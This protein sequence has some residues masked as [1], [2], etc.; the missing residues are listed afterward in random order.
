MWIPSS[1]KKNVP[2]EFY[3]KEWWLRYSSKVLHVVHILIMHDE[4]ILPTSTKSSSF[5]LKKHEIKFLMTWPKGTGSGG[6]KALPFI[7][8]IVWSI[9]IRLK[10]QSTV[11]GLCPCYVISFSGHILTYP[12]KNPMF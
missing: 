12:D 6:I 2:K 11:V 1:V 3:L 7:Y 4:K 10:L 9:N 8:Q 5:F